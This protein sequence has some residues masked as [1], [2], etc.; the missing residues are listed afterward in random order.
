MFIKSLAKIITPYFKERG[1]AVEKHQQ[2]KV[3][4]YSKFIHKH[5]LSL[6][7]S[8]QSYNEK[9]CFTIR[10]GSPVRRGLYLESPNDPNDIMAETEKNKR[11][12]YLDESSLEEVLNYSL[13][14]FNQN[15]FL[16]ELEKEIMNIHIDYNEIYNKIDFSTLKDIGFIYSE[17][18][19]GNKNVYFSKSHRVTD[20][21]NKK[22][23][24]FLRD[25]QYGKDVIRFELYNDA[26][27][28]QCRLLFFPETNRTPEIDFDQYL[29]KRNINI[30]IGFI[31]N[32][33]LIEIITEH[34]KYFPKYAEEWFNAN[35]PNSMPKVQNMG[36]YPEAN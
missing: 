17:E 10:I 8:D 36:I 5:M 1:Y 11:W 13:S 4:V 35:R 27:T 24:T 30:P 2:K 20:I 33:E 7:Y 21:T 29:M 16:N 15:N 32:N 18:C 14:L 3:I 26:V 9:N 22:L 34:I 31:N 23:Y 12:F 6:Y 19:S 28:I 25:S